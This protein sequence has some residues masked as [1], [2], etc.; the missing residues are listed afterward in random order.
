M[1]NYSSKSN[2]W[3]TFSL[4]FNF[5]TPIYIL[6]VIVKRITFKKKIQTSIYKELTIKKKKW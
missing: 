4:D 1:E 2:L 5:R 6:F 3:P